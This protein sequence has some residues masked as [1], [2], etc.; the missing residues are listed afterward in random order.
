[1]KSVWSKL[2]TRRL[3]HEISCCFLL[4]SNCQRGLGHWT[5]S[6]SFLVSLVS[7]LPASTLTPPSKCI[8]ARHLSTVI[9]RKYLYKSS[10]MDQQRNLSSAAKL[11]FNRAV[12][13]T[14]FS[15]FEFERR[16]FP[17]LQETA[18]KDEVR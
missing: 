10:P 4:L 14:K 12:V 13:L 2:S 1:M 6:P 8:L 7:L 9:T 15:R 11:T 17:H 18:L 5:S 16:R 3:T